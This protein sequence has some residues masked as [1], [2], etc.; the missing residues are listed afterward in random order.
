MKFNS[1]S[2]TTSKW[3]S[4]NLK[5]DQ[6]YRQIKDHFL[7]HDTS[8]IPIILLS[9]NQFF[10]L[11]HTSRWIIV[12]ITNSKRLKSSFGNFPSRTGSNISKATKRLISEQERQRNAKCDD[13]PLW[14]PDRNTFHNESERLMSFNRCTICWGVLVVQYPG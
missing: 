6:G 9:I 13:S 11:Y 4:Y 12:A 14:I 2:I 5:Y 10:F 3:I 8:R 7:S 1:H